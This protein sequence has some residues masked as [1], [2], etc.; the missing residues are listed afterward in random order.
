ML[1]SVFLNIFKIFQK[2]GNS[3]YI[4]Y[5]KSLNFMVF[6]LDDVKKIDDIIYKGIIWT[7]KQ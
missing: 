6:I 4:L 2:S 7:T 1:S 3:A 5:S